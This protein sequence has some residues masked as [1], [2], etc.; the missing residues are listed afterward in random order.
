VVEKMLEPRLTWRKQTRGGP[1]PDVL[2]NHPRRNK[3]YN[4]FRFTLKDPKK[5]VF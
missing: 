4:N 1:T 3:N 2:E 5:Y